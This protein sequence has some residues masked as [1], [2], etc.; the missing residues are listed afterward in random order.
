M[1]VARTSWGELSMSVELLEGLS[2]TRAI[3]RFRTDPVPD[4][5]LSKM[6]FA[7]TRAPTGSNRQTFRFVVLRDSPAAQEAKGLLGETFRRS[8]EAKRRADGYDETAPN[9]ATA[10]V[11]RALQE[12][13]DGF[14]SIPVVVL[15][16]VEPR[17]GRLIDGASIYPACQNLLL[18]ARALGY[19]GVL[20]GWHTTVEDDLKALCG[21][22]NHIAVAAT[23]PIGVP[24]GNHGPV[25][26][27]PIRQLVFEDRWDSPAVWA[28]DP[29]GTRFTG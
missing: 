17:H 11:R 1:T 12:F 7:A 22:P 27:K 25:R 20:T 8:W 6:L 21:I 29:P 3:R 2:T 28:E 18:A 23:I 9:S 19:G 13:V 14:E 15:P 4:A 16:C 26:R 24:K 10:R 5:D